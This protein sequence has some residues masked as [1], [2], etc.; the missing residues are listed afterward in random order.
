MPTAADSVIVD[1]SQ[2]FY[3]M[4]WP[5]GG[6]PSDLIASIQGNLNRYPDGI[7]K[8]V[9]FDKYQDVSAKDHE[10][11]RRAGEVIIDYELSITSPLS[12]RECNSKEQE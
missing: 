6:S 3:H 7:E 12:K 10:I 1:V 2:L 5:H 11:M 9:V 4:V 8:I